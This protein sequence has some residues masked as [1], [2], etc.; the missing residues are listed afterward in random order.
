MTHTPQNDALKE[1]CSPLEAATAM[2]ACFL[3]YSSVLWAKTPVEGMDQLRF[4]FPLTLQSSPQ[5]EA[6]AELRVF[7]GYRIGIL[8]NRSV[9]TQLTRR[10]HAVKRSWRPTNDGGDQTSDGGDQRMI[11]ETKQMITTNK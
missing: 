3:I 7:E 2:K 9:P 5:K 6:Q 8:D 1:A 4:L 10:H 11:V